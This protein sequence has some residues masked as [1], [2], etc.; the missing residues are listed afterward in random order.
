MAPPRGFGRLD[1]GGKLQDRQTL[2]GRLFD[3]RLGGVVVARHD[4]G[5]ASAHLDDR[6]PVSL[7]EFFL[8]RLERADHPFHLRFGPAE[9]FAV[10]LAPGFEVAKL[11]LAR[12]VIHHRDQAQQ[13]LV[14]QLL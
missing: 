6:P 8:A 11:P 1:G 7:G 13:R 5:P 10:M 12:R 3:L 4:Q 9:F 2:I 14:D